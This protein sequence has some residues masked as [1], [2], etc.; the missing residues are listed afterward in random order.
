MSASRTKLAIR[1]ERCDRCGRCV[2]A[3]PRSLVKVGGGYIYIDVASCESCFA[4]VKACSRGAI[5]RGVHAKPVAS[6][7]DGSAKVV[8]GSRAEA[9]AYKKAAEAADKQRTVLKRPIA[10]ATSP[11]PSGTLTGLGARLAGSIGWTGAERPATATAEKRPGMSWQ[12][13]EVVAVLAVM[14]AAF[15]FKQ[16]ALSSFAFEVMPPAGQVV[17]RSAIL[18][19][20]YGVQIAVIALLAKRRGHTLRSAFALTGSGSAAGTRFANAGLVVLLLLGTRAFSTSWAAIMR[21]LGWAP[22]TLET[23]EFS[24]LFGAG[25]GGLV[26][27]L[28]A[29][30]VVGPIA[31]ELFFRGALMRVLAERIGEWPAVFVTALLYAVSHVEPWVFVSTFVLGIALGW[32]AWMRN[33]LRSAIVLHGVYNATAVLAAYYVAS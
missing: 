28:A 3:C 20:Y 11:A 4:C 5:E 6:R 29:V 1:P 33:S 12:P 2:T 32:V 15:A 7:A 10:P 9:K 13:Q 27:T 21:G 26:L 31:E 8:V 24:A 25:V 14:L 18:A 22:P 19:A 17:A 30:A 23:S 16:V